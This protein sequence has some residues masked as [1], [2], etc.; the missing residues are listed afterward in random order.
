MYENILGELKVYLNEEEIKTF[1]KCYNT[2]VKEFSNKMLFEKINMLEYVERVL[3]CLSKY[4]VGLSSILACLLLK[5][6]NINYSYIAREYGEEVSSMLEALVRIDNVKEKTN[7]E[8]DNE[9]YRKIFVALAKDYRVL[10]IRMVMQQELMKYLDLFSEDFQKKVA[11]ETLD[12]Y[13]PIAHRLGMSKLKSSLENMSIY[14]LEREKYLYI[15]DM[16]KQKSEERQSKVDSMIDKIK[17][18]MNEHN[19][20]YY[21]IKGRP[22]E[23]Y[24]IY[25]KMV[26]K[27]LEFDEL[28][29]LLALR[30]ITETEVNCYEILGYIHAV[31]KPINGKFKDY[32]AVPKSNMYQSLHTSI[33]ADDGNIYEIQIR[34]KKMDEWA[35]SGVAAH[36]KYKE[37]DKGN[38]AE[39]EEKLHFFREFITDNNDSKE[40]EEYVESL[41]KEIFESSIYVMSPRGKV[42]ELPVGS[43]PVD[44]AYRIHSKVG[45]SCV[46][47]LINGVMMPLNTEL[48]TGDIVEIKTSKIHTEPSEGWLQ[49]VKSS[50][51]KNIIRKELQKINQV[52]FRKELEDKG[53]ALLN[54]EAKNKNVTSKELDEAFSDLD[55]LQQ[56]GAKKVEDL[57]FVVSNRTVNP[58]NVIDK[59]KSRRAETTP[60]FEFKKKNIKASNSEGIIV[61]GIDSIKVE[62]SQCCCPI[63]GDEIIGYISRGNGVKVHRV[64]CPTLKNLQPRFIEVSWDDRVMDNVFHQ[65]DLIIRASDRS[66]LLVEIMNTLSVQKIT[67]L[68]LNAISHKENLNAS[69]Q[70][71][72]MVKDGEQYKNVENALK[73]IS[74]VYEVER[75]TRN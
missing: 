8:I 13:S 75:T 6:D 26:K 45:H 2:S 55:F 48:K 58:I 30:V 42:V 44:F 25:N 61:K 5:T 47:A 62:L 39:I 36:W 16:L 32:I 9:N 19:I 29:D 56:F 51:A 7:Y 15:Q 43:C 31:Y 67:T 41:T 12:V 20:P 63:P 52:E 73:N 54:E 22:K 64:N 49:F 14:Y 24:S 27:H 53:E 34:T 72:I 28:Y 1:E 23:I 68:E 35:E 21:S 11:R 74:G 40:N 33:V 4:Q 70:L 66:N 18:L 59:V 71:S 38:Q 69:V 46:G 60:V 57:Y 17:N 10:I 50:Y 65:V 37:G 3:L